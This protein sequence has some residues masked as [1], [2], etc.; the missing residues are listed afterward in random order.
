MRRFP[1]RTLL[2]MLVALAAFARLY[3]VTHRDASLGAQPA[4]RARNDA[5]GKSPAPTPADPLV[6]SAECRPLERA[7]ND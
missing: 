6:P 5:A 2:L 4:E 3:W 1:L 7:L